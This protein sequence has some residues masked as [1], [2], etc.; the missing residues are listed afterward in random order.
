[1]EKIRRVGDRLS[2]YSGNDDMVVPLMGL[3]AKGVV[4]VVANVLPEPMTRMAG[5]YLRG[6]HEGART[7]SWRC[8]R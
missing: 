4:S 5:L 2:F 6:D 7:C 8:C 1:M 3:G